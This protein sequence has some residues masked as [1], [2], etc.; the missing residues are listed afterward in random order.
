MPKPNKCMV[1]RVDVSTDKQIANM[2]VPSAAKE[3]R[4]L[5]TKGYTKREAAGMLLGDIDRYNDI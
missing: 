2:F 3:Y 4:R 1:W 5:R